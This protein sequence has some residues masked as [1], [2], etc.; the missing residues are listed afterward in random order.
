MKVWSDPFC[1][2]RLFYSA[3]RDSPNNSNLIF[4]FVGSSTSYKSDS[5]AFIFSLNYT[6]QGPFFKKKITTTLSSSAIF[7]SPSTGPSFGEAPFDFQI[8]ING[9]MKEG[10]SHHTISYAKGKDIADSNLETV[11]A[12]ASDFNASDVEVLYI[13]QGGMLCNDYDFLIQTV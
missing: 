5:K 9:N 3:T 4:W 10:S 7:S 1:S 13:G 12:G 2:K 6:S 8:G 11:L